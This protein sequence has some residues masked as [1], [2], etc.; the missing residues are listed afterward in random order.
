MNQEDEIMENRTNGKS[1]SIFNILIWGFALSILFFP[2][3]VFAGETRGID[4]QE[5]ATNITLITGDTV[6]AYNISGKVNYSILPSETGID[7]THQIITSPQGTYFIPADIS[8]EVVE[9]TP[10]STKDIL[11]ALTSIRPYPLIC[12]A[13]SIP[14]ILIQWLLV[15]KSHPVYQN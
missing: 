14:R 1:N 13:G 11:L 9:T 3:P 12:K 2:L 6:V 15:L 4:G 10:A 5:E 7:R 8:L